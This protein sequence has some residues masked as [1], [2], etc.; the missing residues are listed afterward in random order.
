MKFLKYLNFLILFASM[1]PAAS[2]KYAPWAL[3]YF[4]STMS[5]IAATLSGG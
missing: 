4:S 2:I 1:L 5:F 3:I